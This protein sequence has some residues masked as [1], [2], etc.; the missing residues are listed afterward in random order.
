MA[1]TLPHWAGSSSRPLFERQQVAH[2]KTGAACNK[3]ALE[4][5]SNRFFPTK[6]KASDTVG[7]W[8]EGWRAFCNALIQANQHPHADF[9]EGRYLK[10]ILS[11]LTRRYFHHVWWKAGSYLK[12]WQ[13]K[14]KLHEDIFLSLHG[15]ASAKPKRV[16]KRSSVV[17]TVRFQ[18]FAKTNINYCRAL[19]LHADVRGQHLNYRFVTRKSNDT[20]KSRKQRL[21][22]SQTIQSSEEAYIYFSILW[23]FI[24]YPVHQR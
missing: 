15:N 23:W 10:N 8:P 18:Q 3:P 5:H 11:A 2:P 13:W 20:G 1:A 14:W 6:K 9:R 17:S 19:I 21:F 24:Y 7:K 12:H 16:D 22:L 4:Q